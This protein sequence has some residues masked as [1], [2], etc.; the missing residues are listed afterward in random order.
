MEEAA[1]C[2][3]LAHVD[4]VWVMLAR[5]LG[6]LMK[7]PAEEV[8]LCKEGGQQDWH[9]YPEKSQAEVVACTQE[10]CSRFLLESNRTRGQ[11]SGQERDW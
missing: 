3:K 6:F 10:D 4:L 11:Q 5:D 1:L 9:F 8:A 2:L 7:I